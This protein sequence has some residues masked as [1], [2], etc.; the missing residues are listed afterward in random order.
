MKYV[1]RLDEMTK[2]EFQETGGKAANLGEMIRG[3][4][5]VPG[6]FCVTGKALD[7]LLE[8]RDLMPKIIG[9]V[10]TMN[11]DEYGDIEGKSAEI[12][13]M[14]TEAQIP[15]DL[16]SEINEQIEGLKSSSGED[17]FVAV[18]SSVAVKGSAVSSFPGM[19]DTYHFIKG[20]EQI[21]ENIRR[22]WASLFTA[23]AVYRRNQQNIPQ[24]KG[25]IAPVV[26][27]MV[28]AEVAGVM[29]TANPITN[30]RDEIMIESNWGLGESI[31]SGEA[32]VDYFIL[33][34][35]SPPRIK[36]KKVQNKTIMVTIDREKG[37]GRKKYELSGDRITDCTLSDEQLMELGELGPKIE[38]VFQYPQDIEWAY[39]KGELFILQSRKV[40]GLKD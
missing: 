16:L 7:H 23:R 24:D 30:S 26:Q 5:N 15:K 22:C 17:P 38:A 14:I 31:V 2:E 13:R 33:T 6:G 9:L 12:R 3:G 21:I 34:K 39:E 1:K 27:R 32:V 18:R 28:D 36:E 29:F 10:G 40:K 37:I 19:M 8:E 25:V 35:D 11:F 20:E 4:F